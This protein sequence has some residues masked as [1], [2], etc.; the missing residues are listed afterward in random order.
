MQIRLDDLQ[1]P[2]IAGLL[3]THLEISRKLS[4][5]ESVHALDLEALRCA[6]ITFWTA[7][8]G[9]RLLGC[10]ALK[11]VE[12][13]HGEIKSMHTVEKHRR[14]GVAARLLAHI[15]DEA[16]SRSYRRLSLETGSIDAYAPARALYARFGFVSTGPFANYV[17]DP[18]SSYMT[19]DLA[20]GKVHSS[21]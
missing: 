5:P 12:P 10:G 2:E 14:R 1:G 13:G 20:S 21:G 11:E 9:G 16:R 19:L 6:H 4:P 18:H 17:L 8:D 3:Q 7:W 15:I